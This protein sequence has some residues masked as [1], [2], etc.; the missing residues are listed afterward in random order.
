MSMEKWIR[1]L[2]LVG[3][4]VLLFGILGG[5]FIGHGHPIMLSHMVLGIIM[6]VVWFALYGS[7]NIGQT[8]GMI[9]GRSSRFGFN[10]VLYG[11]V[12][13]GIL[14]AVNYLGNKDKYNVRWDLTEEGV[15]SLTDQTQKVLK[16][17][18]EPLQIM[19]FNVMGGK[20]A[21]FDT[22][23]LYSH[24]SEKVKVEIIDPNAKPQLVD[25]YQMKQG[26]IIYLSYGDEKQIKAESRLNEMTE[27]AITN[28]IVKLTRGAAK[29]V[30]YLVGHGEPDLAADDARGLK[31]FAESVADEHITLE[32]L[33][34][35]Q[36]GSVPTDAAAVIV[37]APKSPFFPDEKKSLIDYADKGGKLFLLKDPGYPTTT[38]DVADI[39]AHYGIKIGEDLVLDTVMRLFAGPSL[40]VQFMA[41]DVEMHAITQGIA[42]RDKPIFNLASSVTPADK[43]EGATYT[44]LFKSSDKG[45]A[46]SDIKTVF[47][48]NEPRVALDEADVKGPISLAIA[49]EKEL[50]S[51]NKDSIE[52]EADKLSTRIV[53]IGDTDWISNSLFPQSVHRDLGLNTINWLIGEDS[54]ISIRPKKFKTSM[55]RLPAGTFYVLLGSGFFV[56][57]LI[58]IIGLLVWWRRKV[59]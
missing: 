16:D 57:E 24:Y 51:E 23:K 13:L 20:G 14:S 10:A 45:W 52:G 5:F 28:A 37:L 25:K 38:T 55:D 35:A 56:P 7:K 22:V 15:F 31:F 11:V 2:G 8:Q 54:N 6:I 49:Y 40:G 21:A 53:V 33:N 41:S 44:E 39:A 32:S 3:L 36:L 46:E 27:E 30:Y 50:K 1:F 59:V 48:E 9:K 43:K 58:M 18:K 34:L 17:L 12:F 4:V 26:N 47:S 19:L 42:N 29:K